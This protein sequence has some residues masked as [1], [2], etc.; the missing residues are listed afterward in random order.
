V[1]IYLPRLD[2]ETSTEAVASLKV[3][4][5]AVPGETILVVEDDPDVR[6]Y[7][8]AALSDLGYKVIE[9]PDGPSAL[10]VL[11]IQNVDL[12]F[13]DVVLPQGMTGADVARQAKLLQPSVK[14][15]FTTGYARNAIVHQG[16]LDRGIELITKPYRF[17][18]LAAKVRDVLDKSV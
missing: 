12:V 6:I 9:A 15:L 11:A 3:V 4:P 1:K 16:R 14:V 8:V 17:D 13:T 5:Q 7:S 2:K 10:D 18:D